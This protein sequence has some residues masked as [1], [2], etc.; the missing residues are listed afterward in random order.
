[1]NVKD[2]HLVDDYDKC[3]DKGAST[4]TSGYAML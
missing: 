2:F 4:F 3:C 1:M